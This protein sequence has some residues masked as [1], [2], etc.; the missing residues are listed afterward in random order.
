MSRLINSGKQ[1]LVVTSQADG[2]LLTIINGAFDER[3]TATI[4]VDWSQWN[5]LVEEAKGVK[6]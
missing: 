1:Q 3:Y 5:A 2:V 6:P 4:L